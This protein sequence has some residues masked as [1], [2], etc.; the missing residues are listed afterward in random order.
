MAACVERRAACGASYN[1]CA[2]GAT[3]CKFETPQPA[4]PAGKV[5]ADRQ[6]QRRVSRRRLSRHGMKLRR[7]NEWSIATV[8]HHII[9]LLSQKATCEGRDFLRKRS[10]EISK[11]SSCHG[12][13]FDI[14]TAKRQLLA[15]RLSS[16]A[17]SGT[18]HTVPW[19]MC[20]ASTSV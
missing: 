8:S 17:D 9:P 6:F 2:S 3:P 13:E 14:D 16:L 5:T 19:F 12:R 10:E 11:D 15:S 18:A 20:D 1:A 4:R 7:C